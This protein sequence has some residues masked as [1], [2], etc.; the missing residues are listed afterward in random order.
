MQYSNALAR[1]RLYSLLGERGVMYSFGNFWGGGFLL[2][3]AAAV[4]SYVGGQVYEMNPAWPWMILS[5][6]TVL[7]L[8]LTYMYIHE[9]EKAQ[10]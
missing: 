9:P 5:A 2:F 1:G 4:G 10:T 8:V 3:P 7:S 6:A